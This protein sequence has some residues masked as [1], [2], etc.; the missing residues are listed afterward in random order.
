MENLSFHRKY[1]PS[2]LKGYIGNTRL[3]E[4]AIKSLQSEKLPQVV[5]LWGQSGCGKAQP[6][7]SKVLCVDGYK[8]MGDIK[9]GDKV[10]THTG[11]IGAIS[12]VFPQGVKR[13]YRITLSDDT[14]IEVAEKHLNC[15]Y[16]YNIDK[17]K[18]ED[19]ILTTEELI[20]KFNTKAYPLRVDAPSVD[21]NYKETSLNPYVLGTLVGCNYFS[22][23]DTQNGIDYIPSYEGVLRDYLY[24]SKEV[25][26]K[27]LQGVL[28]AKDYKSKDKVT[29][30]SKQ[31]SDDFSFLVRSLGM[32][33]KVVESK[34]KYT[35]LLDVP[36]RGTRDII[37]IDYIGEQEC[38][39]IMVD[40]P[41]HTYI[42]DY[43]IPTHNT[44]FARILAKEY[45][46]LNKQ[47]GLSC[48]VCENCKA[49]D[50]YI[51][52]GDTSSLTN[53]QEI[54]ITDQS[55]KK[56]LDSV[57]ADMMLPSYDN[58]WK[59]YIFDECHMAT[60]GLQ[61]RLL[62]IAEEPPENV[63]LLLCTTNPERLID[64]LKNRC[65]LQLQVTKPKLKELVGLLK[66]VCD[67]EGISYDKSGLE[68]IANRGGLTIRTALVNLQQ[69]V[70]E[71]GNALYASAIQVFDAVS[72]T[73]VSKFLK[74]LLRRDTFTYISLLYEIKS[75]T[76]LV[77]FV[78]E[79]TNF[80]QRGIYCV[81]SILED[82]ITDTEI[83]LY[84]EIF[85]DLGIEK[86]CNLLTK[87]NS[88]N[89]S[90]LEIELMQLGYSGIDIQS[91]NTNVSSIIKLENEV[92]KELDTASKIIKERE[93]LAYEKGV[94]NAENY[95]KPISIEDLINFG[96]EIVE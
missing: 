27:L 66:Y 25:R 56:D 63:L 9:L 3:K 93:T 62:K 5:L 81:N 91:A 85:K 57:L 37:S 4:T 31:L 24:N 64:T 52:S 17:Q 33:D 14:Y 2:T 46:C 95:S 10:F 6:L 87:I 15:V 58:E 18:R 74:S 88:L 68:F 7:T 77:F 36:Y 84:Q 65:Q 75:K 45:S 43:F 54:D 79:L 42:S 70:T 26:Q 86:I 78:D 48:G 39:C 22:A 90:N 34:N 21:W 19:F 61:N 11:S 89:K 13:V 71:Q 67:L 20:D 50:E 92:K 1:R 8:K 23:T 96:A 59:I 60:D 72:I 94:E 44:T 29:F 38:Q 73:I 30:N 28:D 76:D 47:N 40:H 16:W 49:I 32:I 12:G 55:G 80:I 51:S 82:G 41:D 83:R 53:I 35:H 69:V